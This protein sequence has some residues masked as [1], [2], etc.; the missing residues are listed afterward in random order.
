MIYVLCQ[1]IA[2]QAC[3]IGVVFG[4]GLSISFLH[5]TVAVFGWYLSV[6]GFFHFSEYFSTSIYN[7]SSLSVDSFLLNHSV[8]YGVA[9]ICSWC[10]FF[11]EMYL[12]P[13]LLVKDVC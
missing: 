9:A 7:Y 6:L 1:Q 4:V 11:L 8:A 13:G 5:Q 3:F 10:E 2:T 12:F